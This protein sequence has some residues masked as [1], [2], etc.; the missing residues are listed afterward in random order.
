[1]E[2][3]DIVPQK[4]YIGKRNV[5]TIWLTYAFRV[6]ILPFRELRHSHKPMPITEYGRVVRELR[7][8]AKLSLRQMAEEIDYSP[9]FLSAVEI[10]EK[11]ITDDLLDKV[12]GCLRKTGRF[13][14]KDLA[15]LRAAADRTRRAVDVSRL[16][17]TGRQAV[18]AFARRW[19][20]LDRETREVFLRKLDIPSEDA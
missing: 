17:R 12:T 6:G 15:R 9:T 1:M 16:N 19:T 8:H 13:E 7:D 5:C 14:N 20:D 3:G 4:V 18:A 10:G 11:T 2:D